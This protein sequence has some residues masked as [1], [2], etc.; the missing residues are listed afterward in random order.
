[1]DLREAQRLVDA[2]I[3]ENGGYWSELSMLA[4]LTEE[5]GELAR[6]YNHR[7]GQKKKKASEG[8]KALADEMGDVLFILICMANQQGLD[9]GEALESV[10]EK[11]RVRDAGRHRPG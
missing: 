11:I 7:F 4:R 9:L 6:E 2:W 5:T 1:M 10:L 3:Q 8:D